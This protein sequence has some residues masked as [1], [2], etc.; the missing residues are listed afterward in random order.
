MRMSA[1]AT[2]SAYPDREIKVHVRMILLIIVF[3]PFR[4]PAEPVSA[5]EGFVSIAVKLLFRPGIFS[6]SKLYRSPIWF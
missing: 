1:H 2:E 6:R 4:R 3:A 5:V